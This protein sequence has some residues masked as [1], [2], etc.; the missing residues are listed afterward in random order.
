M[1]KSTQELEAENERLLT[2]N[3][4]LSRQVLAMGMRLEA[5]RRELLATGWD[6]AVVEADHRWHLGRT[7]VTALEA[8]NPYRKPVIDLSGALMCS[9]GDDA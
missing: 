2:L 3:D 9:T 6:A 7:A 5:G 8:D 4:G 1:S